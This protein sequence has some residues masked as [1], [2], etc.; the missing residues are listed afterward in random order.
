MTESGSFHLNKRLLRAAFERAADSYDRV[1]VLQQEVAAR[2]LERLDLVRIVP[3]VVLD[4]GAGTGVGSAALARRYRKATVVALDIAQRMLQHARRHRVWFRGQAFLCGDIERLPVMSNGIDL[5]FSNL[6]LQWCDDLDRALSELHRVLRPGG[7]LTFSTFGPDTLRE[8]RGSWAEVD[9]FNH[10]N[11]FIDM[12]DIGDALIRVGFNGPVL[13]V[14]RLT[15]TYPEVGQLMRELKAL[16]AHNITAGRRRT[17][18]G[19]GRLQA[20]A[21]VY[22][23]YRDTDGRLPATFEVIYGHAWKPESQRP[24]SARPGTAQVPIDTLRRR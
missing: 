22:E 16:G 12:H 2:L 19:K 20:L 9:A 1:A 3:V 24:A 6:A 21:G 5:A 17:L 23:R 18:S 11:A 4:A 10:V 14:E 15:L 8:L 7:L 13:D